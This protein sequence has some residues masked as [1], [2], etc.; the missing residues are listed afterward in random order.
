MMVKMQHQGT[1]LDTPQCKESR[2]GIVLASG[3]ESMEWRVEESDIN[4][5]NEI[6]SEK[7]NINSYN[8]SF[9]IFI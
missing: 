7:C 1:V 4:T 8:S 2:T 9:L 6:S 3:K 5:S